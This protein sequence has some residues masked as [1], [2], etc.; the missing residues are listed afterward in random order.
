MDGR[1]T[2]GG[3]IWRTEMTSKKLHC[4]VIVLSLSLCSAIG[5][6]ESIRFAVVGDTQGTGNLAV[7]EGFSK[8]VNLVLAADPPV[9]FVLLT[10]DL[11]HG[12]KDNDQMLKDFLTWRL[13]AAPWYESNFLGLKVYPVPGNH[14]QINMNHYLDIWQS[15]FPELPDNG[16]RNEKKTTYSFDIGPCR[17]VAVN[18]SAATFPGFHAVNTTWLAKDLAATE[19]PVIFVYGHDPAFPAGRHIGSSLDTRPER[20][21]LFWKILTENNVKI[22]FCGHEHLYDHWM[23]DNVHQIITGSGGVPAE[24]FNYLI[25]DV[26]DDYNVSVSVYNANDNSLLDQF[27][28]TDTQTVAKEDRPG[29]RDIFYSFFDYFPCLMFAILLAGFGCIGFCFIADGLDNYE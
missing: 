24:V 17:F 21:D 9:Q 14:D 1:L 8:I 26:D 13:I 6:A 22:Y 23:K 12:T 3:A 18:T 28:L 10:G 20:R 5:N 27:D 4:L 7:S 25:V 15:A 2:L 29:A 16:P 11:I 19:Q